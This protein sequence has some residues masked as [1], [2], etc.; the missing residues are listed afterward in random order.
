[1]KDITDADYPHAK[2]ISKD[3]EIKYSGE[4]HD[5]YVQS[6]ML[7][8]ADVSDNFRNMC[9]KI[10]ELDPAK[11]LSAPE[12]AWKTVLKNTKVKL[13]YLTDSDMLLMLEKCIM[14]GICHFIYRYAKSNN[15]C[16]EDYDKK[17]EL[18][19]LQY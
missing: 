8:L 14:R 7:L 15:K 10:S 17:K 4:Y 13:D 3:F 18:S 2:R 5:F 1:M 16:I 11:R 9:L 12:L 6:D 19:Y